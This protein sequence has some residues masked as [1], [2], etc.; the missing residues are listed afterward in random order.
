MQVG[1]IGQGYGVPSKSANDLF[2][3][4]N[5]KDSEVIT[6]VG[7]AIVASIAD[8]AFHTA[9]ILT[10]FVT[11]SG[12]QKVI[13]AKE[14][15]D[16]VDDIHFYVGVDQKA[17]TKQGLEELLNSTIKTK[18]FRL[19][20]SDLTYHPKVYLFEGD[21]RARVIIGSANVTK[22]GLL[23]NIEAATVCDADLGSESDR[24]FIQ[25]VE[26]S[27]LSPISRNATTLTN[28]V[29]ENLTEDG[30]IGD[31]DD[32]SYFSNSVKQS[33]NESNSSG[34]IGAD[35][36]FS[37]PTLPSVSQ[38]SSS[39]SEIAPSVK[40]SP[41]DS[42]P[43]RNELPPIPE[44]PLEDLP[45]K[46]DREFYTRL[47]NDPAK[48]PGLMRRII[49]DEKEITQGELKQRLIDNHDYDNSGSLDASLRVLWR[50]TK[51]VEK[52]GRGSD[53]QLVWKGNK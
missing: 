13:D 19:R 17:T 27:L 11:R 32:R 50:T 38:S 8:E 31:E 18:V 48:Q 51:E 46:T 44:R 35:P 45:T 36:E 47:L 25:D 34:D 33:E 41:S 16:G 4:Q 7:Q 9:H 21:K 20:Q 2:E 14:A 3:N 23:A 39:N 26:N 6:T 5:I 53:A 49:F 52:K 37:P 42:L 29:L 1:F 15:V 12:V 43:D 22:P 10:A 28:A 40:P 24:D 30:Q